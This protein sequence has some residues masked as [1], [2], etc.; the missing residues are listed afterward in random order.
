MTAS[1]GTR[2]F[3][4]CSLNLKSPA[5]SGSTSL[6]E[7]YGFHRL[8]GRKTIVNVGSVG[9]RAMVTRACYALVDGWDMTFRRV[10]YDVDATV[11]KIYGIPELDNFLGDRLREG[12]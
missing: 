1:S 4:V 6:Q 5:H 10:E 9:S 11:R 7:C 2:T 12:R 3:Q 8:D